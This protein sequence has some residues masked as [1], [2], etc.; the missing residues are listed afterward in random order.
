MRANEDENNFKYKM[1]QFQVEMVDGLLYV[2]S[3]G[4][5][6]FDD[7]PTYTFARELW[8]KCS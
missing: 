5:E 4:Y 2:D 7:D 8:K 1:R 3:V 6:E